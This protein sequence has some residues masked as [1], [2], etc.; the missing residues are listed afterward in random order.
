[1]SVAGAFIVPH[2]PII[3]PEIGAGEEEKISATIK[4]RKSVV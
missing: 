1:M 2:P 4:D 3:F